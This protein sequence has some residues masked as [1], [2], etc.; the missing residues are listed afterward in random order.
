[1]L[2][3]DSAQIITSEVVSV[4]REPSGQE[5]Q[6]GVF[7][8]SE[9]SGSIGEGDDPGDEAPAMPDWTK[10]VPVSASRRADSLLNEEAEKG[11]SSDPVI[12]C[13]EGS[14]DGRAAEMSPSGNPAHSSAE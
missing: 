11:A 8:P 14:F 13:Q 12:D 9:G 3:E 1:M 6:N 2:A 7:R 5:R 10:L 4:D